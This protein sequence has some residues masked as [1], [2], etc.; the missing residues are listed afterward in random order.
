MGP[1]FTRLFG[2]HILETVGNKKRA[3]NAEILHCIL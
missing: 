2:F 3:K 1:F